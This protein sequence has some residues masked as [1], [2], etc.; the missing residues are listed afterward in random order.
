LLCAAGAAGRWETLL[1]QLKGATMMIS[2]CCR[3]QPFVLLAVPVLRQDCALAMTAAVLAS[4]CDVI[5]VTI[6]GDACV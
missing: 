6:F 5:G 2:Y 3:Q 4:M 1:Q